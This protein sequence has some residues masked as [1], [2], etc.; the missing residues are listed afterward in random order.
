MIA[1]VLGLVL[2]ASPVDLLPKPPPGR[3]LY[4]PH[5]ALD[6]RSAAQ[7][8]RACTDLDRSGDGQLAV[9]VVDE[10]DMGDLGRDEFA[11]ELFRK[12]GI[13][14]KGRDDGVL[15]VLKTGSP[16]HRSARIEVGYGLE[17]AL[18]DGKVGAMLDQLALPSFRTGRYGEG[19]VRLVG[20]LV[21]LIHQEAAAGGFERR[22]QLRKQADDEARAAVTTGAG[23]FVALLIWA[24][25]LLGFRAV[26]RP[27]GRWTEY[28]GYGLLGGGALA[29][30][31]RGG[32]FK[33]QLLVAWA[34]FS[35]LGALA[36]FAVRRHRCPKCAGW[37]NVETELLREPTY[38]RDGEALIIER[39]TR[40][41]YR[42]SYRKAI[43]RRAHTVFIGGGGFGGGGGGGGFGGGG[44][45]GGGDDGG[46]FSGFGGG[47]SG[48]GGG[49]R[50]F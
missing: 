40:C 36:F 50:D 47:S 17:G 41:D 39:C 20:A 35:F 6:A 37:K 42:R 22:R 12:W 31:S 19:L 10:T 28:A 18:P 14:H 27:P 34:L 11:A 38:W 48:G 49:G 24:A 13:G 25:V 15:I 2:L 45:G 43:A 30:L 9:A 32:P 29:A 3:C 8:E 46:G 16:G 23:L 1:T 4:D 44:G 21:P 26:Q 7:L 33:G 5:G